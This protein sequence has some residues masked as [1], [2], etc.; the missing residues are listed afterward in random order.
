MNFKDFYLI[1][2]LPIDC[3]Q[4]EASEKGTGDMSVSMGL[5]DPDDVFLTNWQAS[6]LGPPGVS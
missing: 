2:N 3:D 6:I 5:S 1:F 4:L